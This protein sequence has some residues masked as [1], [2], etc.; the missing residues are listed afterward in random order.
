MEDYGIEI[1]FDDKVWKDS[2][3]RS[4]VCRRIFKALKGVLN[5]SYMAEFSWR[6][7]MYIGCHEENRARTY[8]REIPEERR[9]PRLR[10]E[11]IPF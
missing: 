2:T 5:V 9:P 10:P 1:L 8:V 6:D 3:E 7:G 4:E 11:D